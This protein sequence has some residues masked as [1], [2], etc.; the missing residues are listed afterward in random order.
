MSEIAQEPPKLLVTNFRNVIVVQD[1]VIDK[2]AVMTCSVVAEDGEPCC[3]VAIKDGTAVYFNGEAAKSDSEESRAARTVRYAAL[4]QDAIVKAVWGVDL[5]APPPELAEH[6]GIDLCGCGSGKKAG[7][8][9]RGF[10]DCI[11]G[12]ASQVKETAMP[13]IIDGIRD[14]GG[15]G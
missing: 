11:L 13:S 3:R 2:L 1:T 5:S 7:K 6:Y 8:C 12:R 15:F 9:N 14:R 10:N 4:L